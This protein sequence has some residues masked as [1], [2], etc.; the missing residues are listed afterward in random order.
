MHDEADSDRRIGCPLLVLWGAKGVVGSSYDVVETWRA[1][2][3]DVRGES[4]PCGHYLPEE[5]PELLLEKLNAFF[6]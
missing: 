2:A 5:A 6:T 4:L 1:K 3:T